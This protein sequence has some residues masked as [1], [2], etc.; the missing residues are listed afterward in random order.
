ML[1]N[2]MKALIKIQYVDQI[3]KSKAAKAI[4]GTKLKSV[5]NTDRFEFTIDM[6][7]LHSILEREIG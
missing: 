1:D 3:A 5:D 7:D 6:L 2:K 4:V